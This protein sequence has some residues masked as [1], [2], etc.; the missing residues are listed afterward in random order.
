MKLRVQGKVVGDLIGTTLVKKGK[1]VV[2]FHVLNGFGI[3]QWQALDHRIEKIRLYYGDKV[4]KA[5]V[6]DFIKYGIP[7]HKYPYEAQ[8]VLPL[9]HFE[10][11]D[12]KQLSL[13]NK[14]GE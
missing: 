14:E 6:G 3:P 9:R 1:Q 13:I 12:S 10:V 7:Y 2:K 8:F 11:V 5:R 4:Y